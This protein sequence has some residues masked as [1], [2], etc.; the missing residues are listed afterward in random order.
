MEKS[1]GSHLPVSIVTELDCDNFVLN[2]E[3]KNSSKCFVR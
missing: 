2:K 3:G 1:Q